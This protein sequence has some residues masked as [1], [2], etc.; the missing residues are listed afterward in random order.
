M[1][2]GQ[3]GH[4]GLSVLL[5]VTLVSKQ[6]NDSALH[7]HHDMGETAALGHIYRQETATPIPAQVMQPNYK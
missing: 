5:S 7:R 2:A 6:E 4:H 1:V 3:N